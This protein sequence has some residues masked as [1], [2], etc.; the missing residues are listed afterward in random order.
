MRDFSFASKGMS[1]EHT[2]SFNAIRFES[3]TAVG[4][5]FVQD[6]GRSIDTFRAKMNDKLDS[7]VDVISRRNH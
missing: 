3:G 7:S 2:E 1:S 5:P 6:R 4:F